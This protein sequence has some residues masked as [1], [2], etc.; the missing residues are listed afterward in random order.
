MSRGRSGSKICRRVLKAWLRHQAAAFAAALAPAGS[1]HVPK[2][3]AIRFQPLMMLIIE[4]ELHLF[5]VA[6][7]GLERIVGAFVGMAFREPRQRLGPAQR[8]PLPFRVARRFAPGRQ[9]VDAL[10]GLALAR[11]LRSYAC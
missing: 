11:G 9:Q 6:E 2:P 1:I 8:G 7:L 5:L 10:L 4:R 3:T